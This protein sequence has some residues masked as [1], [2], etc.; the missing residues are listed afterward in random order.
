MAITCLFFDKSRIFSPTIWAVLP[1][2]PVSISSN[3]IVSISSKL[4]KTSLKASI[5][6]EISP[7]EAVLVRDVKFSPLF[8]LIKKSISSKPSLSILSFFLRSTLNLPFFIF[9]STISLLRDFSRLSI[10]L[11]LMS[12][13]SSEFSTIFSSTLAKILVKLFLRSSIWSNSSSLSFIDS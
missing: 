9:N 4:A 11:S 12:W 10:F 6:L 5:I 2:M 1:L 13:I 7:P 3:I 8:V